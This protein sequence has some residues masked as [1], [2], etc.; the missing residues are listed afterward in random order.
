MKI[1]NCAAFTLV[2]LLVVIG[3][4]A[5]LISILLPSLSKARAAAM[6][7]ACMANQR[8]IVQAMFSY[9]ADNRGYFPPTYVMGPNPNNL[10]G[11][12]VQFDWYTYPLVGRYL[13][14][15]P[16]NSSGLDM[17]FYTTTRV[18]FCPA[19]AYQNAPN[20]KFFG[21]DFGIG[22]NV[23]N[24]NRLFWRYNAAAPYA[25][26]TT[27]ASSI[28]LK[29]SLFR[30]PAQTIVLADSV[31]AVAVGNE[32]FRW[33]QFYVNQTPSL[34][35]DHAWMSTSYRHGRMAVVSFADGHVETFRSNQDDSAADFSQMNQGLHLAFLSKQVK[36]NAD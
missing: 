35:T 24:G 10:A 14:S 7:T 11:A 31:Q 28:P 33:N 34:A 1:R 36:D 18:F 12:W 26:I 30:L 17:P 23:R 21:K 25:P 16:V 13:N 20:S 32:A 8:Q 5:L 27:P 6:R 9:S 2:E 3:I 29:Q 15:K 4:I 22:Y 19:V